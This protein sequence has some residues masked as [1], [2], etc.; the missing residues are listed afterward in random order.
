MT[1]FSP[2]QVRRQHIQTTCLTH[3][4]YQQIQ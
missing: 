4:L 1:F 2:F 3:L